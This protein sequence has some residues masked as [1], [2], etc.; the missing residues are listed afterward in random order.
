MTPIRKF[1]ESTKELFKAPTALGML[2]ALYALLLVT[3]YIFVSTREATVWQVLVTYVLL[4]LVPAEFFVLQA[5]IIGHAREQGFRW[6]QIVRDAIKLVAITIPIVLLGWALWALLNK[7]QFRYPAPLPPIT[8]GT[9]PPK[10]QPMHWPTTLF[11]TL[12]FLLFGFA[13]PLAAI[14]LWIEVT[15]Q[16][17]K[18]LVSAGAGQ[19]AKRIGNTL[20]RAF[21]VDSVFTYALGLILFV[22]IPYAALNV[23]ITIKGTKTAFTVFILRLV[24]AFAL[25]L[26]GWVVTLSTLTKSSEATLAIPTGPIQETPAEASA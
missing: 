10:P 17:L 19:T 16:D 15:G 24:I 3:F 5:A 12:R 14:H 9:A 26:I 7:W 25:I 22:F 4:M 8:F 6:S 2:A 11:A 1:L 13:L 18:A 21:D 23:P 20:S